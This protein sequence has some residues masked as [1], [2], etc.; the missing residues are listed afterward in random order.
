MSK[1]EER[2]IAET[3]GAM[4]PVGVT[5]PATTP[6]QTIDF[7]T[8]AAA[9]AK[10][11]VESQQLYV[12]FGPKKH[13]E[14]E[15]WAT[16]ARLFGYSLGVE[17]TWDITD[18]AGKF[19]GA[20]ARAY[21]MRLADGLIVTTAESFCM[22]DE[23]NWRTK[24][25]FQLKSMAQTRAGSKAAR[26]CLSWVAVLGGYSPTPAEEMTGHDGGGDPWDKDKA[27]PVEYEVEPDQPEGIDQPTWEVKK[28]CEKHGVESDYLDEYKDERE[29]T[30]KKG[31]KYHWYKGIPSD[32]WENGPEGEP[33]GLEGVDDA[34]LSTAGGGTD[35]APVAE[36]TKSAGKG[37]LDYLSEIEVKQI[38][39]K[40]EKSGTD[41]DSWLALN[42]FA[43]DASAIPRE[44]AAEIYRRLDALCEE[45]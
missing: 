6:K 40:A 23:P 18:E 3:A 24:P 44:H 14:F 17:K 32:L 8:D 7:A 1:G 42:G 38:R 2:A 11:I 5:I 21:L 19:V 36:S 26:M 34:P 29:F 20:G 43:D 31:G 30:T 10:E 35:T 15:A 45:V 12:K 41:L 16:Y 25:M 39:R 33:E 13:L 4:V 37:R 27:T 9:Q 28:W 22:R